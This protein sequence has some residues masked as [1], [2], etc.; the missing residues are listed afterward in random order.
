MDLQ[1]DLYLQLW[2]AIF[3]FAPPDEKQN[4]RGNSI[5]YYC[6]NVNFLNELI[7][8]AV[9]VVK[10]SHPG[11]DIE[12]VSVESYITKGACHIIRKKM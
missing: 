6:D 11:L 7:E 5:G 2:H 9:N 3:G 12:Y 1:V 10:A 4:D 8:Q